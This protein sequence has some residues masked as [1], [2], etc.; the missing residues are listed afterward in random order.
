VFPTYEY[1]Q[2]EFWPN[3]NRDVALLSTEEGE[4]EI[5]A[6]RGLIGALNKVGM[7]G[8]R[9]QDETFHQAGQHRCRK[10]DL[11][12]PFYQVRLERRSDGR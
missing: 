1:A 9:V 12:G 3:P 10:H 8:W 5:P 6:D 4:T 11:V 7:R 2:L